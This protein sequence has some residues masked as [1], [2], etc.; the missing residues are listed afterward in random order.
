MKTEIVCV[1]ETP[2]N[3]G[4]ASYRTGVKSYR[5]KWTTGKIKLVTAIDRVIVYDTEGNERIDM[6]YSTCCLEYGEVNK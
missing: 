6:P 2:T 4:T 1:W 3:E 5:H